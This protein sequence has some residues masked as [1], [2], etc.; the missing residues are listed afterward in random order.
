MYTLL[1][2]P[3]RYELHLLDSKT[4]DII[5][6]ITLRGPDIS[7]D[8]LSDPKRL[9]YITGVYSQVLLDP[10]DISANYFPVS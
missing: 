9:D 8:M 2:Q 1:V 10:M 5:S 3:D 6:Y 7:M 4:L